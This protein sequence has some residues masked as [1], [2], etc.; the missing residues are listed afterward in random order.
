M[1][2]VLSL[3]APGVNVPTGML[4]CCESVV[5]EMGGEEDGD[6]KC[7]VRRAGPDWFVERDTVMGTAGLW[8]LR[9]RRQVRQN[10]LG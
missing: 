4:E 1:I 7:T 3:G 5:E 10:L 2:S 8:Y 9:R 6:V